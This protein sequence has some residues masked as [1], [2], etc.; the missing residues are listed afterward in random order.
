MF[1][2]AVLLYYNAEFEVWSIALFCEIWY[3][4]LQWYVTVYQC[5]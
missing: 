5:G 1:L 3:Y 4:V 2:I